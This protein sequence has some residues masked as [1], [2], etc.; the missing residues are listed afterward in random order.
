MRRKGKRERRKDRE[1]MGGGG[2]GKMLEREGER[3]EEVQ[4][5]VRGEEERMGKETFRKGGEG[6]GGKDKRRR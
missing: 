4:D 1:R 2:G 5:W 6:R 3:E